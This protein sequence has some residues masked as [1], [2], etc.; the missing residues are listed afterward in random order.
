MDPKIVKKG[1]FLRG[2]KETEKIIKR[3]KFEIT[4]KLSKHLLK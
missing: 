4:V 1:P 2:Y 3:Q